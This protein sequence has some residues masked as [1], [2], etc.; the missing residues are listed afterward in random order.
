MMIAI[1]QYQA[2]TPSI[3][4][5]F[6]ILPDDCH[7]VHLRFDLGP[8]DYIT[9]SALYS[10]SHPRY[11]MKNLRRIRRSQRLKTDLKERF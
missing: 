7:R 6:H 11:W 5:T 10:T 9:W 8:H 2:T 3:S 1:S 4:F